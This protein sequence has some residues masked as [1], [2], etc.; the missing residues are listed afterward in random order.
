MRR[1]ASRLAF[2]MP[3]VDFVK[4]FF[5]YIPVY[6]SNRLDLLVFGMPV[7]LNGERGVSQFDAMIHD[8]A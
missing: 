7:F 3:N 6:Q 8:V 4:G 5:E 2:G 1:L